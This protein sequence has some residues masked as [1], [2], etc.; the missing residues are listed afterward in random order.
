MNF[1]D[2][3]SKIRSQAAAA[4]SKIPTFDDMAAQ[5]DY[6]HSEDFHV[7]G[8]KKPKKE[9]TVTP[10]I[11][12]EPQQVVEPDETSSSTS[13]WSLLDRPSQLRT[14]M[15]K[16]EPTY[17]YHQVA[18]AV[19]QN[20]L[21]GIN[22]RIE[23]DELEG[24]SSEPA[25]REQL[26]KK[27][28]SLPLFPVVADALGSKAESDDTVESEDDALYSEDSD[29]DSLDY[30]D[31]D[32][33]IMSL[34]RESESKPKGKPKRKPQRTPQRTKSPARRTAT[35]PYQDTTTSVK[36]KKPTRF[37]DDLDQR[38]MGT[39]DD[40]MEAGMG[41]QPHSAATPTAT[42]N[43]NPFGNWVKNLATSPQLNR[44]LRRP[45]PTAGSSSKAPAPLARQRP[46]NE[47]AKPS[48]DNFHVAVSSSVLADDE[49]AKLAKLKQS[50]THGRLSM[51]LDS[52]R[53]NRRF[54]F[55]LFT[56]ILSALVYFYSRRVVEDDVT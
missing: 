43:I 54:L 37:M 31:E 50:S 47:P 10:R 56:L 36:K 41:Q 2:Y 52:F 16:E 24:S 35:D 20:T 53:E 4:A 13:S 3:A 29:D 1:S 21:P 46:N 12:E 25:A 48:A 14:S 8:Q 39:T 34:I 40:R 7:S 42:K 26:I 17:S 30:M 28:S 55:I 45:E 22:K 19:V 32:D 23:Y 38:L 44:L 5:D 51:L 15:P 27:Q 33:P 11:P 49:L 18:P 6:I 9:E